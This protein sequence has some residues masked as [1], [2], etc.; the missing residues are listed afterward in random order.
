VAFE[1]ATGRQKAEPVGLSL[2]LLSLEPIRANPVSD[3]LD[4]FLKRARKH[5]EEAVKHLTVAGYLRGPIKRG[6]ASDEYLALRLVGGNPFDAIAKGKT[7]P[8]LDV[9][10][11][12]TVE[13]EA[14]KLAKQLGITLQSKRGR[15][16]GSKKR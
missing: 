3:T 12:K 15:P 10:S 1:L 13:G 7:N 4:E 5:Y 11:Q 6:R 8:R 9:R 2:R 16:R 14:R